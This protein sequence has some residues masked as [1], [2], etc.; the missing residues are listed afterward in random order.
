M[1]T[2]ACVC[3]MHIHRIHSSYN[4]HIHSSYNMD[5]EGPCDETFFKVLYLLQ[6][7]VAPRYTLVNSYTLTYTRT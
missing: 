4:M 1:Y 5:F 6:G 2:C 3:N 7:A